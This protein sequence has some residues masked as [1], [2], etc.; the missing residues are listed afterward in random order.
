MGMKGVGVS[1][2]HL[3]KACILIGDPCVH[4]IHG[5]GLVCGGR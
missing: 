2:W 3:I 1:A 4:S 5:G